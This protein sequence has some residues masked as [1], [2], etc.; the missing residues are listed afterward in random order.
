[1]VVPDGIVFVCIIKQKKKKRSRDE[2][3]Y[4]YRKL[5]FWIIQGGKKERHF[6]I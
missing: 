4:R 1:M 2:K 5:R 6:Y 3:R